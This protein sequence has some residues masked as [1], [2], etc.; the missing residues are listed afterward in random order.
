[1]L[2]GCVRNQQDKAKREIENVFC[3]IRSICVRDRPESGVMK[4]R[5]KRRAFGLACFA[6]FY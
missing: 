4:F 3:H 1:L 6:F 2:G 5:K